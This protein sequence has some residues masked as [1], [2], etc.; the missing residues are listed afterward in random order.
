M[1]HQGNFINVPVIELERYE[2]QA[3]LKKLW[4]R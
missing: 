3:G 2:P 1:G 4:Q